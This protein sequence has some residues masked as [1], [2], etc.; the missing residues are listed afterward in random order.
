MDYKLLIF[1]A[2]CLSVWCQK[3][4]PD[5]AVQLLEYDQRFNQYGSEFTYYDY[6]HPEDVPLEL[7][8]AFQIVVADPPY[9][10]SSWSLEKSLHSYN[11]TL[12]ILKWFMFL[13][14]KECLEKVAQT[15]SFLA[16]PEGCSLLL[17]TGESHFPHCYSSLIHFHCPMS[18][19]WNLCWV[20]GEVQRDRAA[21]LLGL[22]PCMF[23]P[24]HSSKLGNE[25]RLFT[26]YDPGLRLGGWEPKKWGSYLPACDSRL[27]TDKSLSANCTLDRRKLQCLFGDHSI[28]SFLPGPSYTANRERI[29]MYQFRA[30]FSAFK[31]SVG[32]FSSDIVLTAQFP[33]QI[34]LHSYGKWP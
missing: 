11:P 20:A 4:D 9:L 29:I 2:I 13:Q 32:T 7:K 25:F 3:I 22:Q 19:R 23:R 33:F 12:Q 1:D 16:S 27:V 30:L 28:C 17:L 18:Y 21:E 5:I 15:I 26:N 6:N 8:H 14:S 10:V 31:F 24:Q 34:E